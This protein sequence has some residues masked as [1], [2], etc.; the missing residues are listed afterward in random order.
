MVKRKTMRCVRCNCEDTRIQNTG[1]R[2][3]ATYRH[4]F[5]LNCRFRFRTEQDNP[6]AQERFVYE[7]AKE[8]VKTTDR[9]KSK[10]F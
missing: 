6:D 5:C 3:G 2:K 9:N 7:L 1:K 10:Y 4:R 8:G